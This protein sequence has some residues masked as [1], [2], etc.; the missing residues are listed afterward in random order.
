MH[1]VR[2]GF[3]AQ[4]GAFLIKLI[5]AANFGL[6]NGTIFFKL[7]GPTHFSSPTSGRSNSSSDD[8][9]NPLDFAP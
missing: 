3:A 8:V 6:N 7:K 9:T 2:S 1:M 4:H 5:D